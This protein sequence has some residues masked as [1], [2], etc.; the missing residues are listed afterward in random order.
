MTDVTDHPLPTPLDPATVDVW[1][2]DINTAIS[3][4]QS[5]AE[6]KTVDLN[7]ADKVLSRPILQDIAE[8]GVNNATATGAVTLDYSAGQHHYLTLT[9]NVTSLT[10]SNVAASGNTAY[11]QIWIKQ[12]GTGGRT[13]AFPSS[14][15]WEGDAA[16]PT[17]TSTAGKTDIVTVISKDG[18]TTWA[19]SISQGRTGL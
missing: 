8:K 1:G 3:A 11:V 17:I 16:A 19:A 2:D 15:V 6:L 9:G 10:I 4:L 13:V 12:D 18:G 7:F 5:E 14:F